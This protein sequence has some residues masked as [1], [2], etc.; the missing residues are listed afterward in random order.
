[1]F[2]VPNKNQ[3]S[4]PINISISEIKKLRMEYER[5]MIETEDSS[6]RNLSE[7]INSEAINELYLVFYCHLLLACVA[8]NCFVLHDTV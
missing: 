2:R 6:T 4:V 3:E 8:E 7:M 1:M 5:G